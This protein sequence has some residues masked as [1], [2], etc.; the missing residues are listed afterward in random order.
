MKDFSKLR[1]RFWEP[2][3]EIPFIIRLLL[4]VL[5]VVTVAV[6]VSKSVE[7]C[8]Q[9]LLSEKYD[10]LK[11]I[12][13]CVAGVVS[14]WLAWAANKR[15]NAIDATAREQV[16]ATKNTE[17]GQRQERLKNAI[18]HLGHSSDSVRMGGAHELFHLAKDTKKLRQTVLDILCAHIRQTTTGQMIR[19]KNYQAEHKIKPSE[20]IQGLLTLLFMD[21][22]NV[23]EDCS[24][25]LQGSYLNGATLNQARLKKANLRQAQLQKADLREAWLQ[26]ADLREAQLERADLREAQ[27]E[28]ADLREARLEKADLR[29]AKL[30]RADLGEAKLQRAKLWEAQLQGA[31][32]WRAQLQKA[33]LMATQLQGADLGVAQFQEADLSNAQLQEVSLSCAGMQ[34]ANLSKAQ[35][36]GAD[37]TEAEMQEA[38]LSKAQLQG[39]TLFEVQL[40]GANLMEAQL[41]GVNL[42]LAQLQGADLRATKLQGVSSLEAHPAGFESKI[43]N[44]IGKPSDLTGITFSGGL[45]EEDL[46]A[47]CEDLSAEKAQ[48]LRETLKNHVGKPASHE[49]S[50]D[51]DAVIGTYTQE[52]A[53]R[54]IAEYNKAMREV[55]KR[56]DS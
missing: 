40:Q 35:L 52:E 1:Q 7:D 14:I 4:G 33:D 11:V 25:N 22:H 36:Q 49:L 3:N 8:L 44:R 30:Q 46:D 54:W 56:D 50:S 26:G 43:R 29:E 9:Q 18:E 24:I 13:Y 38:N 51:R 48:E 39:A 17:E 6:F 28:R 5:T 53:E 37:L 31:K 41:Q 21:E 27:L 16:N 42:G 55:P 47:L 20:E 12:G 15:A 10:V 34:G 45:Q 23:F 2:I 19:G 32:L